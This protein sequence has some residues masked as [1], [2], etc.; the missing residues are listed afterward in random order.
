M[1]IPFGANR[2]VS[3]NALELVAVSKRFGEVVAL[4]DANFCL[5]PGTI[6]ALLGENGAGKTSLMRVAFGMVAPDAGSILINGEAVRFHAPSDA[7]A[8]GVAMVQQH[9]SLIPAFTSVENF[10][11]G[12]HGT[13]DRANAT[14]RLERCAA[15]LGLSVSADARPSVLSAAEQQQLEI[16]KALGRECRILILDE[17]GAVLPPAQAA[18]LLEWLRTYAQQGHSVVLVT[19]KLRDALAVADDVTVLR[20]GRTVLSSLVAAI[21]EAQLLAAML[22]VESNTIEQ[23]RDVSPIEATTQ[24]RPVASLNAVSA[25]D[26]ARR[27]R[28]HQVTVEIAAGEIVG[29]AGVERSGHRLLLRI[30]A[31]RLQPQ[32]GI[33]EISDS[34]GFIPEDRH[35][36]AIALDLDVRDNIALREAG[37]RRGWMSWR[38]WSVYAQRL[39]KDFDVRAEH[40]R[41]PVAVLSGGNQQK[42]VL[43]RELAALPKLIVA[44][45]PTRGLDVRAASEIRQRL[46][47]A[48]KSGAAVV[49]YSSDLD[50]LVAE[51][52]RVLVLYDGHVRQ[53][54]LS[55]DE[56]GRAMLGTS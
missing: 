6:H 40:E 1:G 19:H 44:E 48:A 12:G 53:C 5:R 30:L 33:A 29:I 49:W 26:S 45:N 34:I 25:Q 14:Q 18:A 27:E 55:R 43:A 7:I 17:P 42:L 38:S 36:E 54:V 56:I 52:H 15:E 23:P 37:K 10:A 8:H 13:F 46:R 20:H 41:V 4:T 24:A 28:L 2:A 3:P 22:G 9:F 35:R 32:R 31:G 11:L 16:A 39:L 51:A 21:T 50:E 47:A